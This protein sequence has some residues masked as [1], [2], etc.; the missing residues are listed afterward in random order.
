MAYLTYLVLAIGTLAIAMLAFTLISSSSWTVQS[1]S[2]ATTLF[3]SLL[4]LAIKSEFSRRQIRDLLRL[5][6]A[7]DQ[8]DQQAKLIIRTDLELHRTQEEL[9][10]RLASLM[11]LHQLGQQLDAGDQVLGGLAEKV[12]ED[13]V[14][15]A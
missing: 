13:V 11:S 4:Y 2:M 7:Y 12:V 14:D 6:D 15:G 5:R 1:I 10:H 8:L 3:G 9:D